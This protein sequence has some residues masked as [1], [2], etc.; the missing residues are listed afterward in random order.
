MCATS[1][2]CHDRFTSVHCVSP[3][4]LLQML[5]ILHI[6]ACTDRGEGILLT[7]DTAMGRVQVK[8]HVEEVM[9]IVELD[10]IRNSIVGVPGQSGD[11]INLSHTPNFRLQPV[12]FVYSR[13]PCA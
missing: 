4:S 12:P 1:H 9:R 6:S 5:L 3:L 10:V 2:D 11:N 13:F 7:A 8:A